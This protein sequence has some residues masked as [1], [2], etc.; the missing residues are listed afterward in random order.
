M[1]EAPLWSTRLV[2]PKGAPPST[3]DVLL[4]FIQFIHA[5][6]PSFCC[7]GVEF[8]SIFSNSAPEAIYNT[9][10][11]FIASSLCLPEIVQPSRCYLCRSQSLRSLNPHSLASLSR[12]FLFQKRPTVPPPSLHLH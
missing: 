8:F 3:M 11:F 1:F 6:I 7:S 10:N 2:F 4:A 5:S 9:M 12:P